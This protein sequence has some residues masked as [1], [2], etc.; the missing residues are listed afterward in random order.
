MAEEGASV[1]VIDLRTIVPLDFET[2]KKSLEKTG[3]VLIAHEDVTFM[4]F[5]AE[6]AAKIAEECFTLLDAPVKRL[7]MKY[8]AAVSHSPIMESAT[9]PQNDDVLKAA[10]ELLAF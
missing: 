10:R 4:G 3:R 2:I 9:L 6:V 8:V 1:E 5:G 7:G